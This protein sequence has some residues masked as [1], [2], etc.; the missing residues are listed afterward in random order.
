MK[1]RAARDPHFKEEMAARER[2]W[3][4]ERE[5]KARQQAEL[6]R[7][8]RVSMEQAIQYA[9]RQQPGKVLECSLNGEHWEAP[10]KLAHDGWVFYH[11][12]IHSGDE[13]NP[14]ITHIL[15]NAIDGSIMKTEKEDR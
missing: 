9:T 3:K 14:T 2:R 8:A 12:V 7:V 6:V 1:E 13:A 11:V 15:V 10:G 4:E 5:I